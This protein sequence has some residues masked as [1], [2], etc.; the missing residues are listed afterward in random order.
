LLFFSN[1]DIIYQ[2]ETE[3]RG[4]HVDKIHLSSRQSNPFLHILP[5]YYTSNKN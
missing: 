4:K 5:T 2:I 1:K 3:K